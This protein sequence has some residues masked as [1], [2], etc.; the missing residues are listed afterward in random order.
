[1]LFD[2]LRNIMPQRPNQ[3]FPQHKI[4]IENFLHKHFGCV[5][6]PIL[7]PIFFH[8]SPSMSMCITNATEV[9]RFHFSSFRNE[10]KKEIH[11]WFDGQ[12]CVVRKSIASDL[13]RN[14]FL[15]WRCRFC[16]LICLLT[17]LCLSCALLAL[18]SY[19]SL[20]FFSAIAK[21]S[22]R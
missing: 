10:T 11:S 18:D 17:S 6:I 15:R 12:Q 2:L 3:Q 4:Q 9:H 5:A 7:F 21:L 16:V 14:G 13:N 19:F 20:L 8:W 22:I 1:M